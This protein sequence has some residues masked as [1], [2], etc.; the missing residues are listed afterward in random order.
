MNINSDDV[1]NVFADYY[2]INAITDG[3]SV[4]LVASWLTWPLSRQIL[5]L[6]RFSS[7][8]SIKSI[9]AQPCGELPD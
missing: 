4:Y 8:L 1:Y 7:V 2:Q 5:Q 9:I 6:F 3:I